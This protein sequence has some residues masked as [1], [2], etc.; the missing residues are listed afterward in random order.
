M[1]QQKIGETERQSQPELR[2]LLE[3]VILDDK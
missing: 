3:V 2:L 1:K